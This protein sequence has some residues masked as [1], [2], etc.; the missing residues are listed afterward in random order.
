MSES[1]V[2]GAATLAGLRCPLRMW[3]SHRRGRGSACCLPGGKRASG[4]VE[5]LWRRQERLRGMIAAYHRTVMTT[6]TD[7]APVSVR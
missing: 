6:G 4:E 2:L 5:E 1:I 3:W 7:R